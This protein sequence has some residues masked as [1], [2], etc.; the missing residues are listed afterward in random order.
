ME[1]TMRLARNKP[2][3]SN[4][5]KPI[6][7]AIIIHISDLDDEEPLVNDESA[8]AS[9]RSRGRCLALSLA[10]KVVALLWERWNCALNAPV[11]SF[12]P[13]PKT[14]IAG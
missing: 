2:P 8:M 5:L 6:N 4:P 14:M 1:R 11:L 12:R 10:D 9:L 7:T 3:P 13:E